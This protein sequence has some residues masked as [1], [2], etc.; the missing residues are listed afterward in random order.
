MAI[1]DVHVQVGTTP[2][3]GTPFTEGHLV[4]MLDRYGI[5]K[6]IASATIANSCDFARGNA[7]IK[8]SVG[9]GRI[10]GC[11]VANTQY[12]QESIENM[13]KYLA[14]P[15]FS[16]L[17]INSG[18]QGRPVTLDQCSDILNAH[19]RFIKPVFL[20]VTSREA[21]LAADEIARAFPGIKFVLLGMG[22]VAWRTAVAAAER[23]LNLVLEI[24]G[25][26]SPDKITLGVATIGAH[27]M[28]YGS[29]LPFADPAATIGLVEN[30]DIS[31]TDRRFIFETTAKRLFGWSRSQGE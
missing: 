23:T 7:Q 1:I 4:R 22:G 10:F 3:W 28:I 17:M 5:E 8:E 26:L 15:S 30:G 2:I 6:C 11:A 21:V 19:R 13:R 25:T 16:A 29:N 20:E 24:S 9:K 12:P 27:R 31:E 14:L 18:L